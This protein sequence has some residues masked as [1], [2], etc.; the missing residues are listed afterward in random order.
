M[1]M[2]YSTRTLIFTYSSKQHMWS[3]T[4]TNTLTCPARGLHV[5]LCLSLWGLTATTEVSDSCGREK[6][7]QVLSKNVSYRNYTQTKKHLIP[8]KKYYFKFPLNLVES[9]STITKRVSSQFTLRIALKILVL[10][11]M[12]VCLDFNCF[13]VCLFFSFCMPL[14]W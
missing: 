7:W 2:I 8:Q 13:F 9:P 3:M 10:V 12:F 11:N 14:L 4:S 6:K 5:Q 1:G